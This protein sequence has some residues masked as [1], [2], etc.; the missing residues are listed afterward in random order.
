MWNKYPTSAI[1]PWRYVRP[2]QWILVAWMWSACIS[3][4]TPHPAADAGTSSGSSFGVSVGD[5]M[6]PEEPFM[7][8]GQ[9]EADGRHPGHDTHDLDSDDGGGD[10]PE[11]DTGPEDGGGS[12]EPA[13]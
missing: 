3:N 2:L 12:T 6:G 13:G 1:R 10:A 5:A 11:E 8:G 7:T 9:N 4:P